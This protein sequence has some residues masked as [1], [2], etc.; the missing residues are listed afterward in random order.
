MAVSCLRNCNR[1]GEEFNSIN[2]ESI[3]SK[4]LDKERQEEKNEWLEKLRKDTTIEERISRLEESM[5][6]QIHH[7]HNSFDLRE[8][9]F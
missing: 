6:E 9:R 2:Y 7:K 4:C 3:C 1:C 8:V 5:Y